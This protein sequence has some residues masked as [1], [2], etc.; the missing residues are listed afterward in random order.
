M[1]CL[2]H[3]GVFLPNVLFYVITNTKIANGDIH[4]KCHSY[5]GKGQNISSHKPN[6]N[7]SQHPTM[8]TETEVLTPASTETVTTVLPMEYP[9]K[10]YSNTSHCWKLMY[11]KDVPGYLDV[12]K[13]NKEDPRL[14]V[15]EAEFREKDKAYRDRVI[16]FEADHPEVVA[17]RDA[18][19]A[20]K[21]DE[22][23]GEKKQSRKKS[24]K[25][26]AEV[27]KI[28]TEE[29][30]L[31]NDAER[32]ILAG[33]VL[34]FW[35]NEKTSH[36]KK[37]KAVAAILKRINRQAVDEEEDVQTPMEIFVPQEIEVQ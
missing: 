21:K 16:A 18:E 2:S 24:A 30:N 25:R 35:H 32:Q 11:G 7:P 17:A 10:T 22:N 34:K 28:D 1:V 3:I 6:Q 20:K 33:D 15:C 27:A 31:L 37:K 36:S 29:D 12:K 26:S 8:T 14:P 5:G 9:K 19:K 23:G 13:A 4:Q